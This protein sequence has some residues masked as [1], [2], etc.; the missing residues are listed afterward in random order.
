MNIVLRLAWRNLWRHARRTWLTVGAMVFS[1]T[2]LVFMISF[3]FSMY[4]LM[5]DN[6]LQVF[7]GHMQVQA[8]GYVAYAVLGAVAMLLT[9]GGRP[10]A[11]LVLVGAV[12]VAALTLAW[13][14]V[15]PLGMG[16]RGAALGVAVAYGLGALVGWAGLAR[17]GAVPGLLSVARVLGVG[18]VV[19]FGARA[20]PVS[21][22]AL[23]LVDAAWMLLAFVLLLASRE[24]SV[25]ELRE[26]AGALRRKRP[27]G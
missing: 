17:E 26:F 22:L 14:A 27:A 7:S 13:L 5:I 23:P 12:L 2:L 11:A 19:F 10:R 21:G 6:T 24:L 25:A 8:P 4:E 18:A 9:A 15:G 1:N 3:Q 16:P 20:L